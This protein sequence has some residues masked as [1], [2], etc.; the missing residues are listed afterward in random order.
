MFVEVTKPYTSQY[1]DPICFEAGDVVQVGHEDS[2]YPAWFWCRASSGKQGWVHR[3]FLTT[4]AGISTGVKAYSAKE[5]TVVGGERGTLIHLLDGWM[6][7]RPDSGGE[8]WIP[9]SHI[10]LSKA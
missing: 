5:L 10:Y 2:E 4:C 9:Q 8:G 1:H 3:S 7:V 6:Y